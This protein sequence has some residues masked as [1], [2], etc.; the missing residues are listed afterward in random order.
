LLLKPLDRPD[1]LTIL[2]QYLGYQFFDV[3]QYPVLEERLRAERIVPPQPTKI[4]YACHLP[5]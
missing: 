5:A 3:R 1:R 2:I 4:P